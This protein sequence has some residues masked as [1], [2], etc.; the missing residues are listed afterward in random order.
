MIKEYA[1]L[2]PSYKPNEIYMEEFNTVIAF[3][4]EHRRSMEFNE[5]RLEIEKEL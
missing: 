1:A 2:F 4:A 5:R 3:L